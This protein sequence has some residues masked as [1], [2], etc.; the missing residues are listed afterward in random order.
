M[1]SS[2]PSPE[3]HS[4]SLRAYSYDSLCAHSYRESLRTYS[5]SSSCSQTADGNNVI[6]ANAVDSDTA[7]IH[8]KKLVEAMQDLNK[9]IPLYD[10]SGEGG[11]FSIIISA[12]KAKKSE[13]KELVMSIADTP[14]EV[15]TSILEKVELREITPLIEVLERNIDAFQGIENFLSIYLAFHAIKGIPVA[16]NHCQDVSKVIVDY[17]LSAKGTIQ[18][19][20]DLSSKEIEMERRYLIGEKGSEKIESQRLKDLEAVAAQIQLDQGIA[21]VSECI[22]KARRPL[23]FLASGIGGGALVFTAIKTG[24]QYQGDISSVI[25]SVKLLNGMALNNLGFLA[26]PPVPVAA[27]VAA[28]TEG[29]L[30]ATADGVSVATV[31]A[32]PQSET[33]AL[34]AAVSIA[35]KLTAKYFMGKPIIL[36][37]QLVEVLKMEP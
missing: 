8:I 28:A 4:D 22:Q 9:N 34:I 19:H 14:V 32:G 37:Y 27:V 21:L 33:E 17:Y 29:L 18:W 7:G 20:E 5:R 12:F 15:I 6:D 25:N 10:N 31:A 11:D 3:S 1:E 24:Y 23:L 13:L 16:L 30:V 2:S 26:T 35:V 36:F